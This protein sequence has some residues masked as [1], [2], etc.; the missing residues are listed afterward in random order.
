M[1]TAYSPTVGILVITFLVW[2]IYDL[3][4]IKYR[5]IDATISRNLV[6]LSKEYLIIPFALGFLLGHW[7]G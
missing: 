2:G 7:Y 1:V 6:F 5:G 3:W 4:V